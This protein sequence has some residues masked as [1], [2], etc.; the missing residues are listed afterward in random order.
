MTTTRR[1]NEFR[2]SLDAYLVKS[3]KKKIQ[4]GCGDNALPQWFNTDI[5]RNHDKNIHHLDMVKPFPIRD[6]SFDFIYSEHNIEHFSIEECLHILKE[7]YRILRKGGVARIA[8]PDLNKMIRFYLDD[9]ALHKRY[10][11]WEVDTFMPFYKENGLCTKAFVL[12]NFFRDWGHQVI[13][14]FES[15]KM[16]LNKSGFMDVKRCSVDKSN[17]TELCFIERHSEHN[18]MEKEYNLLETMVVEA[19]K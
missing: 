2:E 19:R 9:D 14:D 12:S 3:G 16:V 17:H 10:M 4:L 8:T 6:D 18:G 11:Q 15:L 7:C 13:F 5:V 1:D